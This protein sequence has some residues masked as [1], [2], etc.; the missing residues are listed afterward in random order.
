MAKKNDLF[1]AAG[2]DTVI[3]SSVK[4]KGNL[5]SEGDISVDGRMVGNITSGGHVTV[6]PNAQIAGNVR[7]ISAAVAG[8]LE[9][10][11]KVEDA[12]S[13]AATGQVY[14]DIDCG[15]IEISLGAVY[16]G[17]TKMKPVKATEVVDRT[18]TV[19]PKA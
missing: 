11:I 17:A 7:A 16:I 2:S 12:A 3:G 19:E 14:G 1:S 10:N 8:R 18:E 15:H 13:L 4:L 9:G 6:G 5:S